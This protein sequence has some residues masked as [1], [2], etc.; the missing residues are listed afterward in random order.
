MLKIIE[1]LLYLEQNTIFL[2]TKIKMPEEFHKE[3]KICINSFTK[4][5]LYEF[6]KYFNHNYSEY[7]NKTNN[8]TNNSFITNQNNNNNKKDF[9]NQLNYRINI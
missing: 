2:L 8:N 7:T 5:C 3:C 9:Y 6:K 1:E 4:T